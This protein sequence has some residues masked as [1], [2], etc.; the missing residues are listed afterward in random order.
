MIA[1]WEQLAQRRIFFGHQ[2][3]GADLMTA[4]S[5][6]NGGRLTILE[7]REPDLFQHPVFAHCR[8]GTNRDPLSKLQDFSTVIN[9]GV[10]ER[11]DVAFFKLCYVDVTAQIDVKN[12]FAAYQEMMESLRE[13]YPKVAFLY[14][15]VPLRRVGGGFLG[16]LREKTGGVDREQEEQARRHAFNQ[17][18]RGVYKGSGRLFDLAEEEATLQDGKPSSFWYRGETVQNLVSDY[19]DDGG[20]LN[21]L[22]AERIAGRLAVC[23]SAVR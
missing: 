16:W 17:L 19:T 8:V 12:L 20:H 18:L 23:L 7:G 21:R 9:A 6:L 1:T 13:R 5:T 10:G 3:V 22:A 4:L 14:V 15:T 11:V 2:S